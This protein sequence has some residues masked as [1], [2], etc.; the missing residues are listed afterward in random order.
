MKQLL[1]DRNN[2]YRRATILDVGCNK[3]YFS[4]GVLNYLA[5]GF[6]T[7][8]AL[9]HAFHTVSYPASEA[10]CGVC[11]DCKE[12]ATADLAGLSV[13][14]TEA[15]DVWC[16]EPSTFHRTAVTK[17]RDATYGDPASAPVTKGG[18]TVRWH[19]VNS[20]VSN[21]SG[22][23]NFPVD[24][25]NE[26]CSLAETAGV[27]PV[28][29]TS[30]DAFTAEHAL[31]YL[32]VLKIDTEGFDPAVLAGAYH[33]LK[34]HR[35]QVLVFE[36]VAWR[37]G[38]SLRQCL[39]YLEELHYDCYMD[40]PRLYKMT[41]CWDPRYAEKKWTNVFCVARGGT[42]EGEIHAMWRASQAGASAHEHTGWRLRRSQQH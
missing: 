26:S 10:P 6:G 37:T 12:S 41:G 28:N 9:L 25:P 13:T 33:T 20:A 27:A 30:V 11:Q 34:Q 19:M 7:H 32:D 40:A 15:V 22:T 16:V 17:A 4:A 3:G 31:P 24:C 14:P 21:Y 39:D 5:P 23:A 8:S 35:A 38:T 36:H 29:I 2:S 1:V 18:T 42:L